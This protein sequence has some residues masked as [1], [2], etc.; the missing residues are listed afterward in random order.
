[1]ERDATA[2]RLLSIA[3]RHPGV[4]EDLLQGW[5]VRW[6]LVQTPANQLLAVCDRKYDT[7]AELKVTSCLILSHLSNTINIYF[8]ALS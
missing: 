4:E 2:V 3:A 1:M 8:F 5:P 6:L 7:K